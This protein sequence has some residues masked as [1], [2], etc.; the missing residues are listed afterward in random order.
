[1]GRNNART[2]AFDGGIDTHTQRDINLS[3]MLDNRSPE[4]PATLPGGPRR[5]ASLR[6][7]SSI[8]AGKLIN[9]HRTPRSHLVRTSSVP[10]PGLRCVRRARLPRNFRRS[11]FLLSSP[12]KRDHGLAR[13][14]FN[15][16]ARYED[17]SSPASVTPS[18]R[19]RLAL[20]AEAT[21]DETLVVPSS[22]GQ[23][24]F[25]EP[26]RSYSC[27]RQDGR[28]VISITDPVNRQR[29]AGAPVTVTRNF[30]L[31]FAWREQVLTKMAWVCPDANGSLECFTVASERLWVLSRRIG[32][33]DGARPPITPT[34]DT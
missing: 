34:L 28:R 31:K 5:R 3:Q 9:Q 27:S 14:V 12:I 1:V 32:V 19:G 23:M 8:S 29:R 6:N 25:R 2:F 26:F 15:L 33:T 24:G 17:L 16:A 20:D 21:V 4:H 11:R 13:P 7:S 18:S 22:L 30:R 10:R